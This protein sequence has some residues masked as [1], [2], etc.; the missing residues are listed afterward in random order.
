MTTGL[1]TKILTRDNLPAYIAAILQIEIDTSRRLGE[2]GY[3]SPWNSEN[4]HYDLPG[5]WQYSSVALRG[6]ELVGYLIVSRWGANLHGHRMGMIIDLEGRVKVQIAQALYRESSAA[7]R[8][9]GLEY[10]SAIVPTDNAATQR[11]Y[12]KEG[13]QQ[14]DGSS[15]DWF[16]EGKGFDGFIDGDILKDREPVPGEPSASYVYRIDIRKAYL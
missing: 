9:D 13:F 16:I 2:T 1:S 15:L 7:G 3:G 14:L 11:Y 12:L 5:K 8:R 6:S 4:I 10:F